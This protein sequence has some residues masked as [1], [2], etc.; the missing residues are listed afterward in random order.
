MALDESDK[1][2]IAGRKWAEEAIEYAIDQGKDF[3]EG[4]TRAIRKFQ[5]QPTVEE[6]KPQ[7]ESGFDLDEFADGSDEQKAA[8]LIEEIKELAEDIPE[9]G[10]DFGMSVLDTTSDIAENIEQRGHV[11]KKQLAALE[12]MLDGL[13]RWF[14]D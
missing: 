4:F 10:E 11:T 2:R 13:R 3:L 1:Q 12:N 14:H 8:S 6:T 5:P 7:Q 9:A